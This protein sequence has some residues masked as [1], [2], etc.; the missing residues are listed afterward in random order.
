MPELRGEFKI[1]PR[2]FLGAHLRERIEQQQRLMENNTGFVPV[3][4]NAF[5]KPNGVDDYNHEVAALYA[6]YIKR[7]ADSTSF[8]FRDK[9][10]HAALR[11]FGTPNFRFWFEAQ[12]QSPVLSDL[13][14]RFLDD[15][16]KFIQGGRR[17]MSL[18]TWGAIVSIANNDEG[19]G[20]LSEFANEFFGISSGGVNRY[21][22]D[23][24]LI[25]TIQCWCSQPNGIEDLLGTLHLLFGTTA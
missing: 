18:E 7:S 12:F 13:H 3:K 17:E 20:K 10:L 16:L 25:D 1:Y 23:A 11:A 2:G 6:S 19:S 5:K 9:V 21:A 4:V 24:S 8:E 15:T 14:Y 22:R